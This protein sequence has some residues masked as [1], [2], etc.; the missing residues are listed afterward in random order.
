M[1]WHDRD[2]AG[3]DNPMR[4]YG[5]PGG[6]W[7]G[8][9]PIFENPF[10][11][12]I[13]LGRVYG[14]EVRVH[15]LFL[16]YIVIMLIRGALPE[17]GGVAA[18]LEI[19]AVAMLILFGTVLLHE[20]GHCIA[21]RQTGGEANEILMW[22]LGG[23][24]FTRPPHAWQ[25][26]LITTLGGPL[27]NV[28][29]CIVAG[30]TLGLL[31]QTWLG[32]AIPNPLSLSL[33]Y[34][35]S[36]SRVL[37]WLYLVNAISFILLLFNLLPIFPLDG[38]RILQE[39]LWPRVGYVRSMRISIRVGLVGA[40][41]LGVFGAV[42]GR[43][44]LVGI[45]IFGGITCWLTHKQLSFTEEMM[46]H[47]NDEY[48]LGLAYDDDEQETPQPSAKQQKQADKIARQ[49]QEEAEELDRILKKIAESGMDSLSRKE[50]Q[51]LELTS[52]RKRQQR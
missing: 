22:P 47:E 41:C 15:I 13:S 49:Q 30:V 33:P 29:I 10:T 31:T 4:S 14:I 19:V 21:C 46:G 26:H 24:A 42:T 40:V 1:S 51:F 3:D 9:R 38:G 39:I 11:W 34:E 20:F 43:Y 23:L 2:Y 8:I 27:V 50:K 48:A 37:I 5:R 6:D 32:V 45:A 7:Q 28:A 52:R 25:A 16:L 18:N 44:M 17:D 12:A 35:V 36:A